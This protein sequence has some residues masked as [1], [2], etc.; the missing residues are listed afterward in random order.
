MSDGGSPTLTCNHEA[1]IVVHGAQDP[2]VLRDCALP[3]GRN[4]GQEKAVLVFSCK[5]HGA[6]ATEHVAP[7][8]RAMG[9]AGSHANAG[10]Q[11]A[12]LTVALRGRDG[13]ATAELGDDVATCL[14][15]ASGGGDKPHVL[16]PVALGFQTSGYG[17]T[18]S[19]EVSPTLMASFARLSNQ[20]HGVVVQGGG[21]VV[22]RLMPIEC[23]RLQGFEDGWT[24]VPVGAGAAADGPR[25]KQIGNSWAVPHARWVMARI[26]A[27]CGRAQAVPTP[28]DVF[29]LWLVVA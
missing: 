25:Y 9:H 3:L 13:G 27:A 16:A 7:T 2:I 8:L 1:P 14:R 15:A 23:E 4:S 12:V 19:V 20:V 22:R 10:G 11:L 24:D 18:V 28:E 5:D 26:D 29:R 17:A 6:D 21:D